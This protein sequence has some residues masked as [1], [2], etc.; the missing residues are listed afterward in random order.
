MATWLMKVTVETRRSAATDQTVRCAYGATSNKAARPTV[1]LTPQNNKVTLVCGSKDHT[2]VQPRDYQTNYCAD[3]NVGTAC[4]KEAYTTF[5]K[6]FKPEWWTKVEATQNV[7]LTLPPEN[8]PVTAKSIHLECGYK[9]EGSR[10]S[11]AEGSQASRPT[12]CV[13]GCGH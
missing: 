3:A 13:G 8:F 4:K 5:I 9:S 6:D 1:T 2:E 10:E 11:Q 12:V 7:T